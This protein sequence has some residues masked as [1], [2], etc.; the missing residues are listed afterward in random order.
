[1]MLSEFDG[2]G[3]G[4]I[5]D[6]RDVGDGLADTFIEEPFVGSLLNIDEVGDL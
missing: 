2:E 6:G 5:L 4:V 3:A 1:M